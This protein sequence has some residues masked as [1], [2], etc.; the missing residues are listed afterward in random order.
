M[1]QRISVFLNDKERKPI[2][3]IIKEAIV[4]WFVKKELPFFYFGK[5]LY[6]KNV[7]NYTD[8]LSS[9]EVDEIT[10]SKKMHQYQYASILRN[11]L[12]FA[13]YMEYNLSLIHI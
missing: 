11:K 7:T 6:R 10:L 9:K 1:K 13:V 4:F 5:F 8:Y 3:K 2:L 12:S